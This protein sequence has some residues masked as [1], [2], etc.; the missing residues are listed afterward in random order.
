MVSRQGSIIIKV[1]MLI[2]MTPVTNNNI[3]NN[4]NHHNPIN[5][6]NN[7]NHHNLTN[8]HNR[9]NLH[10]HINHHNPTNLQNNINHHNN[11]NTNNNSLNNSYMVMWI[12]PCTLKQQQ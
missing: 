2:S 7:T 6:H 11:N 5:P 1:A 10:S 12:L 8:L 9:T 4:T 3:S